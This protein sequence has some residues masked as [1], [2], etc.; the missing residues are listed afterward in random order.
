MRQGP[1]GS[2]GSEVP[3]LQKIME[4][5]RAL[6]EAN[7]EYR[8]EQERIREEARSEQERLRAEA[9]VNQERLREETRLSQAC[10]M[11]K[12]KA[13]P[14]TMEEHTQANEK[15]RKTNEELRRS[16]HRQGRRPT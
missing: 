2:E 11:A 15:L 5:M 12:I 16:L 3:A 10:L 4:T 1:L 8:H 14:I 6:Q 9:R 13:S 7:E